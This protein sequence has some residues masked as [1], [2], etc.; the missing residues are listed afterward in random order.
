ML[1]ILPESGEGMAEAGA[2]L[3][4][5]FLPQL[6]F[7]SGFFIIYLVEELVMF[8]LV[9][10]PH[11]E[12]ENFQRTISIRKSASKHNNGQSEHSYKLIKS[13]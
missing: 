3:E 9:D 5:E 1:H 12:S 13:T 7:C 11:S 2:E 4:I 8:F 10:N 6:V